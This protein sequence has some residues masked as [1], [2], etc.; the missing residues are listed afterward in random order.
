MVPKQKKV[1]LTKQNGNALPKHDKKII[2]VKEEEVKPPMK[3]AKTE[4]QNKSPKHQKV[5]KKSK[6]PNPFAKKAK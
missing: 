5:D 4:I 1:V 6:L 2:A 3:K